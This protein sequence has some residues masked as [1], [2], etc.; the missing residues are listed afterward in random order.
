MTHV[1]RLHVDDTRRGFEGGD[2]EGAEQAYVGT[3]FSWDDLDRDLESVRYIQQVH[4]LIMHG[5][6]A[7]DAAGKHS[8]IDDGPQRRRLGPLEDQLPLGARIDQLIQLPVAAGG[9]PRL[10]QRAGVVGGSAAVLVSA[11]VPKVCIEMARRSAST[12]SVNQDG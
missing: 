1:G 11:A 2:R 6:S 10:E 4:E 5:L 3:R 12:H 7:A 9:S 8:F